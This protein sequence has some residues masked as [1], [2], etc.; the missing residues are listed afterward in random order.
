MHSDKTKIIQLKNGI[1]LLGYGV[2]YHHKLLRRANKRKFKRKFKEKLNLYK[3]NEII[4][5]DFVQTLQGWL[6]YAMWA[7]TYKLRRNIIK[8]ID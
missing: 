1:N 2:F 3:N 6:G 8:I 5:E 7:D 4:Y